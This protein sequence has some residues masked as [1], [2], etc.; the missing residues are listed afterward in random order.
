M[1]RFLRSKILR[2]RGR[3]QIVRKHTVGSNTDMVQPV[4]HTPDE[5]IVGRIVSRIVESTHT[6]KWLQVSLEAYDF[7]I[8]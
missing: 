4:A 7:F 3:S 1:H 8:S 5:R 6:D 2:A